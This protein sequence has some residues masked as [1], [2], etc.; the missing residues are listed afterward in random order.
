MDISSQH[1]P[2]PV[3]SKKTLYSAIHKAASNAYLFAILA[4]EE[5]SACADEYDESI[6][7]GSQAENNNSK[8]PIMCSSPVFSVERTQYLTPT[9]I[10]SSMIV[11]YLMHLL[12]TYY[13][14]CK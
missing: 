7:S 3:I 12:I 2:E 4:E 10:C 8:V 5:F 1:T 11:S 9:S 14:V 6:P 13:L